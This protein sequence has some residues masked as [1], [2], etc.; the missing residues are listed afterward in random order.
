[1]KYRYRFT[2][3]PK[4]RTDDSNRWLRPGQF[5]SRAVYDRLPER[6]RMKHEVK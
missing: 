5:I 3:D 6:D 4:T 1:M 2:G